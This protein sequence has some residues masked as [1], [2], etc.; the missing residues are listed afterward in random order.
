MRIR[1]T[2]V[3]KAL[4]EALTERERKIIAM[5]YGLDGNGAYRAQREVAAALG[6]SRSYV[7]RIEK[8]A[9]EKINAYMTKRGVNL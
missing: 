6:I 7:S 1:S 3:Y 5:R 4:K 2:L 8:T 9:L